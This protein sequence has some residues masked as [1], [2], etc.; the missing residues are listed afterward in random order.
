MN[1]KPISNLCFSHFLVNQLLSA[2]TTK[3]RNSDF[4]YILHMKIFWAFSE[5]LNFTA[6][7]AETVIFMLSNVAKNWVENQ[8]D[9]NMLA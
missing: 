9:R 3:Y 4:G 8:L 1:I 2:G 5:N 6:L 7:V